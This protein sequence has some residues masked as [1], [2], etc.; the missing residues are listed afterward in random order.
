ML[1]QTKD[2]W[3]EEEREHLAELVTGLFDFGHNEQ[4]PKEEKIWLTREECL[5]ITE[6]WTWM[7][8]R[9]NQ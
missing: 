5:L 1:D 7:A 8:W 3:T 6:F 2:E 9:L 4:I